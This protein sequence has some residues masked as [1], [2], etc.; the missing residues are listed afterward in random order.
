MKLDEEMEMVVEQGLRKDSPAA[1]RGL[2]VQKSEPLL[3]IDV[4]ADDGSLLQSTLRDVI[5]AMLDIEPWFT[6]HDSPA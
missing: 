4:V 1:L 5:A 2:T 3:T 6:R